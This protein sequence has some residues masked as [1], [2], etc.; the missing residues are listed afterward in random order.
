MNTDKKI[1][2]D[3]TASV[4]GT[5]YQFYVALERAFMLEEDQKIWIEK[6][7]DVTVSGQEQIET[8]LYN[9]SLTDNHLNFW[10]TL[11]NWFEPEFD[12]HAYTSLILFTTQ[13]IGSSSKFLNWN[14]ATVD[15]RLKK[16][17][18]ILQISEERFK[19]KIGIQKGK[20]PS[21]VLK[22]Q[23]FVLHYSR[24]ERL[25]AII[26]K[27]TIESDSPDIGAIRKKI[28]DR[29]AKTICPAKREDFL[30]DLM[31]YII[32][33]SNA[34]NGW[35]VTF[36]GFSKQLTQIS[37]RYHRLTV[38]FPCKLK[39]PTSEQI[40][41]QKEKRFVHKIQEIEHHDVISEA[42]LHYILASITV[43]EE[44]KNYAFDPNCYHTYANNHKKNQQSEHRIAK[45]QFFQDRVIAS[46][47]FYDKL[48]GEF[49]QPFS[50][51]EQTPIEFRNG[52]LHMLADDESD[53]FQWKLWE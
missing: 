29:H 9:D 6:F 46:Q 25:K 1:P 26:S 52:V 15:E 47:N 14:D 42:I 40:E 4:K 35:E 51:F 50:V 37:A 24:S 48:T 32:S 11:K 2:N 23:R 31:G 36:D 22:E 43:M 53:E 12:Y 44:L 45:R 10:K 7:G 13:S 18:T 38:I 19:N 39:N 41:L 34:S 20:I 17:Q 21:Q 5:V 8:K 3:N 33:S 27:L 30:N 49:P 16:L 28:L